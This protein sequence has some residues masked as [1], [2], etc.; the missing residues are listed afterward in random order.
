MYVPPYGWNGEQ[1]QTGLAA[2]EPARRRDMQRI[3]INLN[4][5]LGNADLGRKKHGTWRFYL[6]FE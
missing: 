3:K 6:P 5:A 2:R 4:A 1:H